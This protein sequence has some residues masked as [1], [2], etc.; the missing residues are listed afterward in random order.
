MANLVTRRCSS[1]LASKSRSKDNSLKLLEDAFVIVRVAN[2]AIKDMMIDQLASSIRSL[3]NGVVIA[4]PTQSIANGINGASG[5]ACGG[6]GGGSGGG[7]PAASTSNFTS[8]V[9]FS[10][11]NTRYIEEILSAA[12]KGTAGPAIANFKRLKYQDVR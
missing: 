6:G 10:L 3:N 4:D 8:Y 12:S 7:I 9:A 2:N 1:D 11:I 5:G